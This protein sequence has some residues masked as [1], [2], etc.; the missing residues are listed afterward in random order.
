MISDTWRNEIGGLKC[1]I[2]ASPSF[3]NKVSKT[4][5]QKM[6]YKS[7]KTDVPAFFDTNMR[8]KAAAHTYRENR[9][10]TAIDVK[11]F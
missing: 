10:V 1:V 2:T 8:T 7:E 5:A 11:H 9:F 3:G 6:K 4:E